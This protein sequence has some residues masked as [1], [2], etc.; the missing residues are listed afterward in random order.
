ME[1]NHILY[2]RAHITRSQKIDNS[3]KTIN[4]MRTAASSVIITG[5]VSNTP[6]ITDITKGNC[7]NVRKSIT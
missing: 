7:N 6:N 4:A 3:A 2:Y 5:K 1:Y